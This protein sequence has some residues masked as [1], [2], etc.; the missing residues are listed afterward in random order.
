MQP[1]EIRGLSELAFKAAEGGVAAVEDIHLSIAGRSFAAVGPLATPVKLLHDGIA[2]SVYGVLR[3]GT[4]ALG[5]LTGAVLDRAPL[6]TR[7]GRLVDSRR[8][9]MLGAAL[10]GAFGDR[11]ARE[12]NALA[13]AMALRVG[14]GPASGRIAIFVHGLM[15][16]DRSWIPGDRV[17]RS[18]GSRLQ[19][20]L[21]YTPVFVLYNSGLHVSENGRRLAAELEGLV[22]GWPVVITEL[23]LI[24]HSMGGL[25]ARSAC[26]YAAA[27]AML[28][29]SLVRHVVSL[30][31]PHL[32]A[33]LEK[34]AHLGQA[35]LAAIPET[36]AMSRLLALRSAGIRDLRHGYLVDEDWSSGH[37]RGLLEDSCSEI[38]LLASAAHYFV[39]ATLASSPTS[40][41]GR[42]LGDIL[43]WYPSA[44]GQGRS[45]RIPF[46][47]ENGR[48]VGGIS[49]FALLHHPAV[50]EHLRGWL[51]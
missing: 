36:R 41:G 22:A 37:A 23:A 24:G 35:A 2:R 40:L 32:G 7:G 48:H 49:H 50:Y 39:A 13:T 34:A 6:P 14:P 11:L 26:H 51:S 28:W 5:K 47:A 10:N 16:T 44:S 29:P 20:D 45:R 8:G 46:Q 25:V 33:P 4:R 12:N 3:G 21:G 27:E 1:A 18:Y 30:G 15:E 17:G 9:A 42:L 38:P 31:T 19:K 43:V